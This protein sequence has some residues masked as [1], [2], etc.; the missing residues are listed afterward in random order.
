MKKK[1]KTVSVPFEVEIPIE[2]LQQERAG[3]I[4]S[5]SWSGGYGGG[6]KTLKLGL[7][8]ASTSN[9]QNASSVEVRLHIQSWQIYASAKNWRIKIDGTQIA[10]GSKDPSSS[11]NSLTTRQIGSGSKSIS[12]TGNKT[13][14]IRGEYDI[15]ITYSGVYV[16][17]IA[18]QVSAA[19][20][21][22]NPTPDAV[23][24][25]ETTNRY[26][27]GEPQTI[28]WPSAARATGYWLQHAVWNLES[29]SWEAWKDT[30]TN[31]NQLSYTF[32]PNQSILGGLNRGAIKWRVAARNA[33]GTSGWREGPVVE[34]YGVKVWNGSAWV[35]GQMRAWNG[36][37]W[38]KV[39]P[40][41]WNGSAWIYV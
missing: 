19:L 14:V 40:K 31:N 34:H 17:T 11:S 21:Y 22:I 5:I 32:T 6:N 8:W 7:S 39:V 16:G 15:N 13:I 2:E 4:G 29:K 37:A 24:K 28:T 35:W 1:N 38:V 9:G 26:E 27:V 36:S 30:F 20:D 3:N 23:S 10:S 41:V 18:H 25:V 12:Y 33:G